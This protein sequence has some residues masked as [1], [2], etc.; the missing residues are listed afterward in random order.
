MDLLPTECEDCSTKVGIV[1]SP[2]PWQKW[3]EGEEVPCTLCDNCYKERFDNAMRS[4][5][6]HI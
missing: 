1:V 4:L 3:V 2:C 6:E 5:D